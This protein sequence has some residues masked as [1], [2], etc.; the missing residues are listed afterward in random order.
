MDPYYLRPE[1]S[2]SDLSKLKLELFPREM[3]DPTEAYRFGNLIDAMI[4]E[5]ERVNY[6]KRTCYDMVFSEVDF[7]KAEQ[8]KAA[9]WRDDLCQQL[10]QGVESQKVMVE[11]RLLHYRGVDFELGVRCKWDGWR[12]D[13]GYGFDI[14]STSATTQ[15]QFEAA[16]KHFDYPRQRAWYMDIANSNYD[17]LIG[18]S[19]VNYKIFKVFIRRGDSLYR[20]G[21]EDYINLA[22]R[23]WLLNYA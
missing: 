17:I 23:Y 3:P 13:L 1:V 16:V 12:N 9:F 7:K 8:M 21:Y 22:F 4:T 18:I 15:A 11:K 19:K 20:E 10:M 14:K 5:P 6:F 2:N